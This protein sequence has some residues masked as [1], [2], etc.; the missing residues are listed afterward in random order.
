MPC[1]CIATGS[2]REGTTGEQTQRATVNKSYFESLISN[3]LLPPPPPP[4]PRDSLKAFKRI[5]RAFQGLIEWSDTMDMLRRV[6][7]NLPR[8]KSPNK[9]GEHSKCVHPLQREVV[10]YIL[11]QVGSIAVAHFTRCRLLIGSPAYEPQSTYLVC[12]KKAG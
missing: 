2:R 11:L 9:M 3:R 6:A 8:L 10:K 7:Q 1:S 12:Q 4:P 5:V